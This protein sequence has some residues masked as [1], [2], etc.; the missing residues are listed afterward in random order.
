[1]QTPIETKIKPLTYGKKTA[2]ILK[3]NQCFSD[4][5][6]IFQYSIHTQDDII[7]DTGMSQL[8][9]EQ[10]AAWSN[11]DDKEYIISCVCANLEIEIDN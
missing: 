11:Q 8:T 7:C 4:I 3:I 5:P 10:W 6:L 1:M 9:S 2:T